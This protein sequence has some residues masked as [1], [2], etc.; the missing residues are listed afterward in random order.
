MNSV[1]KNKVMHTIIN[2]SF[3]DLKQTIESIITEEEKMQERLLKYSKNKQINENQEEL[4]W[5]NLNAIQ[6]LKVQLVVDLTYLK[7]QILLPQF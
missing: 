7:F 2:M 1:S 4:E 6:K 3:K 5:D